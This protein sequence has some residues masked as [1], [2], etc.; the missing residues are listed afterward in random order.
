MLR[1]PSKV[2]ALLLLFFFVIQSYA[3]AQIYVNSA[4]T[5]KADG[6][7]WNNAYTDLQNAITA[8]TAGTEIWVAKGSYSPGAAVASTFTLKNGVKMYGGFAGTETAVSQRVASENGLF[9]TNQSILDGG[10]INYHVI[11][12]LAAAISASTLLDGFTIANGKALS[13][14]TNSPN[15]R[16]AGIYSSLGSAVFQNLWVHD[17]YSGNSG[18][19]I[20]NGG[21]ATY[22]N[23]V[24]ENNGFHTVTGSSLGAG[25]CNTGA[26]SFEK[27]LFQNNT[28]GFSGGGMT[29][30]GVITMTGVEFRNHSV[31]SIGGGLNNTGTITLNK[32]L[33][34]GNSSAGTGGAI[35]STI[36]LNITESTFT[37]NSSSTNGGGIFSSGTLAI[38]RSFFTGNSSSLNGGG[39]FSS[40]TLVIERSFFTGNTTTTRGGGIYTSSSTIRNSVFSKN[41]I[42]GAAATNTGGGMFIAAG[43]STIQYSTF[44]NNAINYPHETIDY[45]GGLNAA[46][47][48]VTVSN[49][50]FW[51]NR[52]AY[53]ADD[54]IGGSK[55]TLNSNLIK[56]NLTGSTNTIIG[57]PDFADAENNDL[58]LKNGSAAIDAG[59][60]AAVN[61]TTDYAGNS[62]IINGQIDIGA[63]ENTTGRAGTLDIRPAIL[64]AI[65]RG[66]SYQ[67]QLSSTGT[68]AAKWEVA[69]G[70][71]PG[72][73][74][75]N[76]QTGLLSGIP[77]VVGTY[78]FVI[79]VTQGGEVSNRHYDLSVNAGAARIHVN[80]LATGGNNGSDWSNGFTTLQAAL[81]VATLGDQ[82]W[83]S[84]GTYTP[85]E[86]LDSAFYMLPGVKIYGGFAGTET[87]LTKR[88]ADARGLFSV[89]E[90]TLSGQNF[91]RHVIQ[92]KKALNAESL[93]DGFTIAGGLSNGTGGGI[94]I[95]A[96]SL[97]G[98]FNNLYIRNNSAATTGGGMH[99]LATA[100]TLNNVVFENNTATSSSGGGFYNGGAN[101][102]L[103]N[104]TFKSNQAT[105]GAGFFNISAD[106]TVNNAIFDANISSNAGGGLY[107]TGIR[108]ILKDALFKNNQANAT[109]GGGMF[110]QGAATIT[111]TVFRENSAK[112][113][114][115]GLHNTAVL[116]ADQLSFIGN[117][118]VQSGGGLYT[119]STNTLSNIVF[120]RNNVTSSNTA[121]YFGGGM[122]VLNGTINL[123]N[124]TFSNN[125]IA[126]IPS[127]GNYGAGLHRAG[128]TVNIYNSIFWGNKKSDNLPDQVSGV[129]S[130][131]T[132]IGF[133]TVEGGYSLSSESILVGDPLFQDAATDLLALKTGSLA[134]DKGNNNAVIG[135]KDVAGEMRIFNAIVDQG[136]YENQGGASIKIGP[137]VLPVITRGLPVDI[138][139]TAEG[140]TGTLTWQVLSGDLPPGLSFSANGKLTGIPM[141]YLAAGYPVAFSVTDGTLI[142][143]KQYIINVLQGVTKI[144]VKQEGNPDNETG[145]DWA[146]AY[147]DLQPAITAAT[148][149]DEIWVARG[150]YLT[151]TTNASSFVLKEGVKIYGGFA[152]TENLIT[153]RLTDANNL[154][155]INES[156]LNGNG[157]SYHVVSNTIALTNN[158]VLD[159]FSVQGGK[160]VATTNATGI[161]AGIYNNAGAPIFRNLWIKNNINAYIGGGAYNN[162]QAASFTNIRFEKNTATVSSAY[163]GGLY[164]AASGVTLNHLSFIENSATFGGGFFNAITDV[165]IED[166]TFTGNTAISGGAGLN[167]NLGALTLTRAVFDGNKTTAGT[168]GALRNRATITAEDLV[169]KNNTSTGSGA[170]IQ[171]EGTLTLNRGSIIA[172]VSGGPGA[173]MYT[174]VTSRL[175]NVIFSRNRTTTASA[176]G[177]GGGIYN[178]TGT[179]NLSNVTF[180]NNTIAYTGAVISGAGFYSAS[181]TSNIYNSIFWNN[182][183]GT[184]AAD[185][186]GGTVNV[187]NTIV[188]G[189]YAAGTN[190]SI[191][192]PLFTDAAADNLRIKGGSSAMDAGNNSLTTTTKD[193]D[194]KDRIINEVV[195]LG[196]YENQ[197]GESLSILPANL[198]GGNRGQ[199]FNQQFTV[200]G[201]SAAF[202]WR[203]ASGALPAGL[204]LNT[205]GLLTGKI[206]YAG[207]ATF[208]VSVT[209]GT[210]IGNK[211]YTIISSPASIHIFVREEATSG[212]RNGISWANAFTDLQQGI[213]LALDGDEIWVAKGNYSPGTTLVSTFALKQGVKIYGGFAGTEKELAVRDTSKVNTENTSTL[214]GNEG[215]ASYH[216][217]SNTTAVTNATIL[218]GFTIKGGST[219]TS[220]STDAS[221]TGHA[222]YSGAG[223]FSTMGSPVFN[224]LVITGNSAIFGAGVYISAGAPIFNGVKFIANSGKGNLGRGAGLQLAANATATLN[225]VVF[226]SNTTIAAPNNY[227]AGILNY[228]NLAIYDAVFKNNTLANTGISQGGAL[229]HSSGSLKISKALF[230]NN[231]ALGGGAVYITSANN[232]FT[233]VTFKDNISYSTGGAVHSTTAAVFNRVYFTGNQSASNGGAYYTAGAA[234]L[235]NVI[236]SRN[237]IVNTAA[238]AFYG[239]AI[240]AN[241]GSSTL[242]NVTFSQNS[243]TRTAVNS[244]GALFRNTGTVTI[245]NSIFWG[246]FRGVNTPDQISGVVVID[247]SIVEGGL[248]AGTNISIGNPLFVD[249]A[250][251]NLHLKAGSPAIDMGTNTKVTSAT[252]I[253]GNTRIINEIVDMGAIEN[254]GSISL[255]IAPASLAPYNR[256]DVVTVPLTVSGDYSGIKWSISSGILPEG[257]VLKPAGEL[258]GRPMTAGLFTFVVS[259]TNGELIGSRQYAMQVKA[260]GT[261][262]YVNAAAA[263]RNDGTSWENGFTD[264]KY[265]LTKSLSIDEIWVARGNYSPGALATSTFTLKDG[266]K[267]YGGFAG[268]ETTLAQ[269]D[270]KLTVNASVLDGSQG[271][272]SRHVMFNNVSL[273]EATLLDGFTI[274]GGKTL[275][276][277]D[278]DNY[279]GGGIYN[280]ASVKARFRNLYIHNNTADKGAGIY[281]TGN[282]ATFDHIT[283]ENNVANYGGGMY[284]ISSTSTLTDL[285]FKGNTGKI[286]GGGLI[287]SSSTLTLDRVSF[288]AN[289]AAQQGGGMYHA[290]GTINLFNVL[291]SRN[292]VYTAGSYY[293]GGL[294]VS[295]IANLT[296]VTFAGNTLAFIHATAIGGAG[297]YRSSGT[298]KIN[299]SI[300]W[301]NTRGAAK[302]DQLNATGVT[303]TH[304][305]IEGGFATGTQILIGNP[306]FNQAEADDLQ[307][308]GGSPA[309]DAADNSLNTSITDL[310]GNPRIFDE[311]IDMGAYE[312]QGGSGL[313]I[314]PGI[315][316]GIV[317]GT[318]PD[319]Q[320][321]ATGGSG[322]YSWTVQSGSLPVGLMLSVD[323]VIKG[324]PTLAGKYTFVIAA[325]DQTL[326]GSKQYTVTVTAG[327]V[328]LY[329]SQLASGY[330]N[331][332]SWTDAFTNLQTAISQVTSGDEIWVAKGNYSPGTLVSSTFTLKE[333]VKI[334]GGFAGT[335]NNLADRDTLKTRSDN[336]TI[337]DGANKN[338]HVVYN[339]SATLTKATILDGFSIQKGKGLTTNSSNLNANFFGAGI[340]N[341]EG[342]AVFSHL[343]IKNNISTYGAGLYHSGDAVYTDILFSD[344]QAKGYYPR[345]AGVYNAKGFKLTQGAFENNSVN[346]IYGTGYGAALFNAA[347]LE[348]NKVSFLNN[349]VTSGQGGA[350]YS[351]T[352][353]AFKI[354]EVT[355]TGNKASSGG[356]MYLLNGNPVLTDLVFKENTSS[357]TG[358]AIYANA[359]LSLN[360][361]SFI[362]N[363]AVQQGGA[364]WSSGTLLVDNSIFSRNR[365]INTAATA[366]YGGAIYFNTGTASINN[367]S[368]SQN[369]ISY[370]NVSKT[371]S[372]GGALYKNAGT[373]SVYNSIFWGNTRGENEPDQLN[374]GI[375][376]GSNI[377]QGDYAA[378]TEIKIG[379]PMFAEAATDNLRLKAGSLAIDAGENGRQQYDRDLD[380]NTRVNNSIIDLG[381]YENDGAGQLL[382]NPVN[383]PPIG[384]GVL[385]DLQLNGAGTTGPVTWSLKEGKLPAG[386]VLTADGQLRGT[387]T[388][389]GKYTFVIGA[390][391]GTLIGNRQYVITVNTGATRLF[392]SQNATG[393]H[394]GSSWENAL[395]DLQPALLQAES[396]DE[397]WVAKGVYIAGVTPLS[398]FVLKEGVKIYGGF[399]GT[400]II[401]AERD[402]V[403]IRG[404][405]ESILQGNEITPNYHIVSNIKVLTAA[406]LLDGFSIQGGQ[407]LTNA[408]TTN[409]NYYGGGIYNIAG[410]ALFNHLWIKNNVAK[411]GAGIYHNGDALYTNIRLTGNQA[412]GTTSRGAGV[413]NLK[414]FKLDGG[415]FEN[416]Q[417]PEQVSVTYGAAIFNAGNAELSQVKFLKNTLLNGQGGAI[418]T[419]AAAVLSI[420]NAEFTA[421]KATTGGAIFTVNGALNL[422]AV[423]FNQNSAAGAGGALYTSGTTTLNRVTFNHNTALLHG[424]AIWSNATLKIDNS[425]FSQNQVTKTGNYGGAVYINTGSALLNNT[426]FSNNT[427][428]YE[429]S[430]TTLSYGAGLYRN[431][432]T[433]NIYNSIFWGNKRG[434]AV[435][436]QVNAGL[437]INSSLV[438]NNY[439]TGTDIKIGNPLFEDAAADNLRLKSGSLAIDAGQNSW[440][441]YAT[442]L[443]GKQRIVK[444]IIDLGAY[445][446]E[447]GPSLTISPDLIPAIIRGTYTDLQLTSTGGTQPITWSLQGGKLPV[448]LAITADGKLRGT[449]TI[450]GTYTFVIG[451]SDGTLVGSRQYTV[452]IQ[453]GTVKLFVNESARGDNNGSNWENAFTDLQ[454]AIGQSAAGD[455]IWVARGLYSPGLLATSTFTL[456]EGVKI[457]GGFAGTEVLL[458]ERNTELIRNTN[459]TILDG[460]KGAPSYHVVYNAAA[461]TTATVVDGFSIQGSSA[462]SNAYYVNANYFGGGIYNNA[463]A[464][465]FN[466]LWIKNNVSTYGAGIYHNG[467]ATY[468][469][470]IFTNNRSTGVYA[471]GS[472]VYNVTG[473]KLTNGVFEHNKIIETAI[474]YG[475]AI[476]NTGVLTLKDI[477]FENN[478]INNGQGGSIYSTG[479]GKQTL[480][481]VTFTGGKATR[482]GAVYFVSGNT[483]TLTKVD[484]RNN[485][486][487]EMGGAMYLAGSVILNQASFINNTAVM[488]GAAIWTSATSLKADN[489][490]FSRNTITSDKTYYGAAVYIYSGTATL[491]NNTFSNNTI[492]YQKTGPLSY[493]G[494]IYRRAGVVTINNSILWGNKRGGATADQLNLLVKV[495]NSIVQGGYAAGTNIIDTDPVFEDAAIDSLNLTGCSPAVNTGDNELAIGQAV[496]YKGKARISATLV[497]MGALE[498][499]GA[500]ISVL[501]AVLPE[502]KRGEA[503]V[504]QLQ[505]AGGNG[506]YTYQVISGKLPDGLSLT[507]GGLITGSPIVSGKYTFTI[508][509]A[510]GNLCGTRIYNIGVTAGTGV[511]RILVNQA[512]IGGQDNGSTWANAYLDLQIALKVSLP[513]DQIWVAKGTYS[514]GLLVTSRYNLKEGLK[515]YGGFAAT[516]TTLAER[517]TLKTRSDNE[518]ILDGTNVNRHV[519]YNAAALTNKTVLDGFS[520]T[521][522]RTA[523]GASTSEPYMGAGIYNL[524]GAPI[525]NNLWIKNNNAST[526][527]GGMYNGGA[528]VMSKITFENNSVNA[529]HNSSYRYGGGLYNIGAAK[530][531]HIE[532]I[533]NSADQG[534]GLYQGSRE[535]TLTDILFK[536]N[537]AGFGGGM[538]AY[539]GKI[540]INKAFFIA[541]T[542]LRHGAG[543]YQYTPTLILTNAIFSRNK[544]TQTNNYGAGIYQYAGSATLINVTLSNNSISLINATATKFGGGI[545]RNSGTLNLQNSIVWGNSR[546]GGVADELNLNI[547]VSNSLVRGGY[548]AGKII[549]DKDPLFTLAN[550]DDL[551]LTDCSAAINI[552]D[553]TFSAAITKDLA[554]LDRIIAGTVDLGAY[555]NQQ[556]R[557][558]VNPEILAIGLRGTRFEQQL[559][560]TGG[561]GNYTYVVSF[562]KL[563]DG[564]VLSKD[565]LISGRPINTG[566][567]TFNITAS[568]GTL[569]GNRLYTAEIK[570]G[571]GGVSIFVNQAATQGMDNGANWE[572]GFLT[573]Q[574]GMTSSLAGDSIFV[575]KGSYSPGILASSYFTLKNK[576]KIFGGFAGTENSL[577]ERDSTAIMTTNET[578]LDGANKSAHVVYN[579]AALTNETV[580]DGFSIVNGGKL[581]L[582][583]SGNSYGGGIYNANGK[584]IFR[585]LWIK[586][587]FSIT[588]GGGIYNTGA[589]EFTNVILEKN[590]TNSTGGGIFNTALVKF[591]QVNFLGNK[592]I[593]GGGI[594]N[595]SSA[596]TFNH[597]LFEGNIAT[598]SGGA[599]YNA[600]GAVTLNGATFIKNTAVQTG[601]AIFKNAG[602]MTITNSV[603]SQNKSTGTTSL[604]GAI[605]TYTGIT[606]LVN[607]SL[608]NN[609]ISRISSSATIFYGGA[610]YR[611]TG[612]VSIHNSILWGNKRGND[613][614][615]QLTT[616]ITAG[617]S[618]IQGGYKTGTAILTTDPQFK[619]A[620]ADDLELAACSPAINMGDNAKAFGTKDIAGEARIKHTTVDLGAYEYQ[621]IYLENAE[622][623]LPAADQWTPYSYQVEVTESGTHSYSLTQGLLPDGLKLSPEGIIS[624]EASIAGDYEFTLAVQG[625]D[626]CGML[627]VKLRVNTKPTYIIEVLKPYP[628]PVKKD[629]G[630]LFEDLKLV[631]EVEVVMSDQSHAKFPVTWI[632]GNYDGTLENIYTLTGTLTVPAAEVNRN[633]LTALARVAVITPVFPY[634]VS[635]ARLDSIQVLSGTSFI[636]LLPFLPKQVMVTYDDLVTKE[637]LNLDWKRGIYDTKSGIYRLYADLILKEEHANPAEFEAYV[638]VY[639]QLNVIAVEAQT[640]ITVALNTPAASLPLPAAVRVTYHDQTTGLLAVTWDRSAYLSTK[641]AEYDL[642]AALMLK[643]LIANTNGHYAE[644]R[645]IIR[646]NIVSV[647]AL[648]RVSTPYNTVFEE[649][650]LPV[651]VMAIF[652]DATTDT[653]GVEWEPGSYNKL[654]PGD[655]PLTGTLIYDE[656]IDNNQNVTAS[657]ILTVLPKPKNIISIAVLDTAN[658]S[659]G[660][661]LKDIAVLKIPIQVTY[662]DGTTGNLEMEWESD[663]Y[664][665]LNTGEY[666][667]TGDPK[668]ITGVT[669]KEMLGVQLI[670]RVNPKA[671]TAI[672]NPALIKVKYGTL[673]EEAGLPETVNVTYN[674]KSKGTEGVEWSSESYDPKTT[675][676]YIFKG[677]LILD[678]ETG[679]PDALYATLTVQVGPKPLTVVTVAGLEVTIPFGTTFTDALL[680]FPKLAA[681]TYDNGTS[682]TLK[683]NWAPGGFVSNESGEFNMEG[684]LELVEGIVNPEEVTA[685]LK[686]IIGKH[687]IRAAVN[688]ASF[689]QVFG[690][691]AADLML[692][693]TVNVLFA[694]GGNE[695]LGV[696]WDTSS[697]NGNLAGKYLIK[698]VF[699]LSDEVENPNQ[700]KPQIEITVLGRAKIIVALKTDTLHVPYGTTLAHL[701]LP[702]SAMAKLDDGTEMAIPVLAGSFKAKDQEYDGAEAGEYLYEG[703]LT[704]PSEVQNPDNIPATVRIVIG[705]KAIASIQP[706]V[707]LQ[708]D[709]D[710]A[711][712]LLTL[713]D[714]VNVKYNDGSEELLPVSWTKGTYDGKVPATYVLQGTITVPEEID[715]PKPLQPVITVIVAE[716]VKILVS[717]TQGSTA[718]AFGTLKENLRI[719][720]TVTG[721]FDDGTTAV[722]TVKTWENEDY[723]P[724]LKGLYSF[725]GTIELPVNTQ[726]PDEVS[727]LFNITV[728]SRY[729]IAVAVPEA[730]T[731][732][733]GTAYDNLTL[734][735]TVKVTYNDQ[736]VDDLPVN[737]LPGNYDGMAAAD[738]L[739]SGTI[740]PDA[741]EENKDN[742]TA[743]VKVT[744]KPVALMIDSIL[745]ATPVHFPYGTTITEVL[746]KLGSNLKVLYTNGTQGTAVVSWEAVLFDGTVPAAYE[747]VG[748]IDPEENAANPKD[749]SAKVQVVID[750]RNIIK[751][752]ESAALIAVYGKQF[753]ELALPTTVKVTYDN[754]TSEELPVLW[755]EETYISNIFTTQLM[756]GEVQ[757]TDDVT[758][759][760]NLEAVIKITLQKDIVSAAL[761][762]PIIVNYGTLF[763]DLG[764]PANVEVT[765]NDGSK[766]M[767]NIVWDEAAYAAASVG[768]LVLTA[769]LTLA[770]NTFNTTAQEASVHVT[771]QKAKQTISFT[772]IADKTYGDEPFKLIALASS[773]LP[774]SFELVEGRVDLTDDLVT[775][776]GTGEVSIKALQPGNAFFEKAE[777]LQT[778][779]INK[780]LLKVY[781]D[782]LTRLF[783]EENP[784]FTYHMSGFKYA[785]TETTLRDNNSL[786]GMPVFSTTATVTTE[787]GQYPVVVAA[788]DLQADHYD[789]SFENGLLIVKSLNHIITWNTMGGTEILP[790]TV[791][792]QEKAVAPLTTKDG[793]VF[794]TWYSDAKMET[795]YNFDAA[796]TDDLTLYADWKM[797]SMPAS[798]LMSMKVIADYM[799]LLGEITV[800]ERSAPFSLKLL[801]TK[802]HLPGKTGPFKLSD[803]YNYGAQKKAI[804]TTISATSNSLNSIN[805]G[806]NVIYDGGSVITEAGV[807]WSTTAE[808]TLSASKVN[809]AVVSGTAV[810]RLTELETGTKY[811]LKAFAVNS[812]GTVYGNQIILVIKEDGLIE[813][814][815]K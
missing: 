210:M 658:V 77:M 739:L 183:K 333:G 523:A 692:P 105:T 392:V 473:F 700:I 440:Q 528:V 136:A 278:G 661:L 20:L 783:A 573:L 603:F 741:A 11:S 225:K 546:G 762:A 457:Y 359:V 423:V 351:N 372:Y 19:A 443:D 477:K 771:I 535:S 214:Y 413:Y 284:Y 27:I 632:K 223:I 8:A 257:V 1:F 618:T 182:T 279:R 121:A 55:I 640:D 722:L 357:T 200:S 7:S 159:G 169:I 744:L 151:G 665:P 712:E 238:G 718:V 538:Y 539:T 37:G 48:G 776:N 364:I 656:S 259:A 515:I 260:A 99:N 90:T 608:S 9:K 290:A 576:V 510:D 87:E 396:G 628:I 286:Y 639:S 42:T 668:L 536:E 616:L 578:I 645:V 442:D 582:S 370:K 268:T 808:P 246:N 425:A 768:E 745:F 766:E 226:D 4:A 652:D 346:D 630:T 414:G 789:F 71:I 564:L 66:T 613:L 441:A 676:T 670:I 208:V 429:N 240:F 337:L 594:Y 418:Y 677:N 243:V 774:V 405:N 678:D 487:T 641:G 266:V 369:N 610:L 421:N 427:I 130:T 612:A 655:Y 812:A 196:A 679:N 397:I 729:I 525:F 584:V 690:T 685:D 120:S 391:D 453:T 79:K 614:P 509:M 324:M 26:A 47:T 495:N 650:E 481:N 482:G 88:L 451:A 772:L 633:N 465:I 575:A 203:I 785:E 139:L 293:G 343:W 773:G 155:A 118:A 592:A 693:E 61:S 556:N 258:S 565:G 228:G 604:G 646:K 78:P 494:A 549:A 389:S 146:N 756:K 501:P 116:V 596:V 742:L 249:A 579:T 402:T 719:P 448:G 224:N 410:A 560:A 506:T 583:I 484:F 638:D 23:M 601:G 663:D 33:F 522:G 615:D 289:T 184:G 794:Y 455:E 356:A 267:V 531:S 537:S 574:K 282:T 606:N 672:E 648:G 568:D 464:A 424:G 215:L 325:T 599:I 174:N 622:Q 401:L 748:L 554:G 205:A 291:F 137:A 239:G 209:D 366:Y 153:G 254:P 476:F 181:G 204:S 624:G 507:A 598:A 454:L 787:P 227:G 717:I 660:T 649:V 311:T 331:G 24:I 50:I 164:N 143:S 796:V 162:G 57:N 296:N 689:D 626:V 202:S 173:G 119:S 725:K 634:I 503:Y 166:V 799:A 10:N 149:G 519:V 393:D 144:Y 241:A 791:K 172:N 70:V 3:H 462:S 91:N 188:E 122:F 667:F 332:S 777:A 691:P 759:T 216:V 664:D 231:S 483:S 714:A 727:A 179:A 180:S 36:A 59:D 637:L 673:Q 46:T 504:Q 142:G 488:D 264:L 417:L 752:E 6:S 398:S 292:S 68:G 242:N 342:A 607:V 277:N 326:V 728:E 98:A 754:Q 384:R 13:G 123:Y 80:N 390:T 302:P 85:P 338:Y 56:N 107:N 64:S 335:E 74:K 437:I 407:A 253:E 110:N 737:W 378:G 314:S 354:S 281:N 250:L 32:S 541:N 160:S 472:A 94:S 590:I 194:A 496:D 269:R 811:Y 345:G 555:E 747:F 466:H 767:L 605:Y 572:N 186:L 569:C 288:I 780:A 586:N 669:N 557:I 285:L 147:K 62:R 344:N 17:N 192:N 408:T 550:P 731:V 471:R 300:F 60:N 387:P 230:V 131:P 755:N 474:G 570:P 129:P 115:A 703:V 782:T 810:V 315:L 29:N 800:T 89:N 591:T 619:D 22:R 211:Q 86:H 367:T 635:V 21:P 617:N 620:A 197:G 92:N 434:K 699:I 461:L 272:A 657:L 217:V 371:L 377:I 512:A 738:Y 265:A 445:E 514:P 480:E 786:Q 212:L 321:S 432:G 201:G 551:T 543:L 198:P 467:N 251:D 485:T 232:E 358:G 195:D 199:V 419:T 497:D 312:N 784:V 588:Y 710:T 469:D 403:A 65:T 101:A 807:C 190:I 449:P 760:L 547:K 533:K 682:G 642:K 187:V 721:L 379:D 428:T 25:I 135:N 492:G 542:S 362:S 524:T 433:I 154:Y 168:G 128:G 310:A 28:G 30:S 206:M 175:D 167:H 687:V 2:A 178:V 363:T 44:S 318:D 732:P 415:V 611:Y 16:G 709:Y 177:Y 306:L 336:E 416:N 680:L 323:G 653:V 713:P 328:H 113:T 252:D 701:L 674:D 247:K 373:V 109:F 675:G 352:S 235:D 521:R 376:A 158:S 566:F 735:S 316:P 716:R 723:D 399:A 73:M 534:G 111:N 339:N 340:Y 730:V 561:S 82:M 468:T 683:V 400:E 426:T 320:F 707:A 157:L 430:S 498:Y 308:K 141:V 150:N 52:R 360:R 795:V 647:K 681:I 529:L 353:L 803:W 609:A 444:L 233:D 460:G 368:F 544:V 746:G 347:A 394:N 170:G 749:L 327:S 322:T 63:Y 365:I 651:K 486:A 309:I 671:V 237:R 49:S 478:T 313:K 813:I 491:T 395:T 593:N 381:A 475:G 804:I 38:D 750:N 95:P 806:L 305:L 236:F 404:Q 386:L 743:V 58:R 299:N 563:P 341:V 792:D 456:K 176:A 450:I 458:S 696:D 705:K 270:L 245:S 124:A 84:K 513:G 69:Y 388:L 39:I 631:T 567:Y 148:G 761:I 765:Y 769:E 452:A 375:I 740:V 350:I 734:P 505:G 294:F 764:L 411:Y 191:G 348:L 41:T 779:M 355:F 54:Q 108:F 383:I 548:A 790:L 271:V 256:G 255:I 585:N 349:T 666:T 138:Q 298:V 438:E 374:A 600:S 134:I 580:L 801:N 275:E 219:A 644:N 589:A 51:G 213:T 304:T 127:T 763:K 93:I 809:A 317:R 276:G 621:G 103:N 540:T 562:G 380:G 229:Y 708:V 152:G 587:N 334:Y 165:T 459:E 161:G 623:Q 431:A 220:G 436:D 274:S 479:A 382:I 112:T 517:D 35:S 558:I 814:I 297:L 263:G 163:G 447:G 797:A 493:G 218:D 697:F 15:Y 385:L 287:N 319:L 140:S 185:Q 273:T 662:D 659:Y 698:G 18:G 295:G 788:G 520:I 280:L 234:K 221:I 695:D 102:V 301:G 171:N 125:T 76:E 193:L 104:V 704:L 553:N 489:S 526:L 470:I 545:F 499:Q 597:T 248:A 778:F 770:P 133:S 753:S 12:S 106:V 532:F 439:A 706:L 422:N 775:V 83:V 602:A 559:S 446:N 724:Q 189:G 702:V 303:A 758:N 757:L 43:T 117:D 72:G 145:A 527:G 802:S 625:P 81:Q 733:F 31:T 516:E 686:V 502:G 629:L 793:V 361:T 684:T 262:L 75:L 307:L 654:Q 643:P 97:T 581:G 711:Y 406:T 126:R 435:P 412:K 726:N 518:T 283:F 636:D 5:G 595:S 207:T 329:V 627:K 132:Y 45:G 409:A 552:G 571:T 420:T 330:N 805:T 736:T 715:N 490:I 720:G 222:S 511:V 100:I 751:V 500:V 798:G 815:R 40:G 781:G 14:A 508:S 688:P 261:V 530:M 114:G 67:L 53:N 244:G 463:G 694:D 34:T 96:A 156:I 577:A